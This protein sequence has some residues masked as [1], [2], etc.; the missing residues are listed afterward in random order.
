VYLK[1]SHS[2]IWHSQ[3]KEQFL[4]D[5]RDAG[6]DAEPQDAAA[7]PHV[8][9]FEESAQRRGGAGQQEAGQTH[10]PLDGPMKRHGHHGQ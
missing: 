4:I 1:K 8:D 6:S 3:N 5:S 9:R 7:H 2:A 10:H